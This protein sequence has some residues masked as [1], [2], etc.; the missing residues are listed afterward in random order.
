[1]AKITG[2]EISPGTLINFEGGLWIAVKTVKACTA[3][4]TTNIT[5]GSGKITRTTRDATGFHGVG[6]VGAIDMVVTEGSGFAVQ[7]GTFA[8]EALANEAL[9]GRLAGSGATGVAAEPASAGGQT[10]YRA[11]LTGFSSSAQAQAACD[12]LRQAGAACIVRGR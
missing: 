1:M 5:L 11:L 12:R 4:G 10:L 2:N 6:V 9:C 7:I 3:T 8:S